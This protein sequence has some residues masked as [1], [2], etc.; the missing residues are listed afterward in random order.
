MCN[1]S[2][3]GIDLIKGFEGIRLEAY[4]P[5]KTEEFWTIGYG[6][7]GKDVSQGQKITRSEAENL[8]KDDVKKFVIGVNKLVDVPVNQNQFDA[9]VS[10]AYNVGLGAF[11]KSTLLKKLNEKDYAGA[12]K[13][14]A[15]WNKADG[16]VLT[17]LTR[18]REKERDLFN[19]KTVTIKPK[20]K[21]KRHVVKG[22]QTL[23][24]IAQTYK[25]D[26]DE[27][28]RLNPNIKNVNRIFI[29]QVVIVPNN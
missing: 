28:K 10:F 22:G 17:G 11:S 9:L 5:V 7:Y 25:T 4:K 29:G 21:T 14:F 3:K 13:E 27:L 18:R 12:S 16:K 20:P 1:I 19:T 2:Q 15:R 24:G 23:S 6:H 26:L 8:L